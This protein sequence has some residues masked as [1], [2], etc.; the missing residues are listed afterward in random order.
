MIAM[1]LA[2][3]P[4]LLIADEPT[5]ALDVTIQRQILELLATL[6]RRH[7]MSVLF[8][9]H[10]LGVVGEIAD[11]VV[12]MRHGLVREGPGG[13]IFGAPQDA[14]TR[15][16]SA[17]RPRLDQVPARLPS[18]TTTSRPR[19]RRPC[20]APKDGNAPVVLEVRALAKSF[21]LRQGLFGKREFKAVHDVNFSC[22]AATRWAWSASR[23]R[24]RPPWG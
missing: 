19:G 3:E 18:S 13:A 11:Q 21:W 9:S 6:Q 7:R 10:D 17:C 14:Y 23:A 12:V 8:I 15:R 24:A 20:A 22:G 5:T 16:C 1:A 2:C 4:R